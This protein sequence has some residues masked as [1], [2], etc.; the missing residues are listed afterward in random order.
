M[1]E[2]LYLVWPPSRLDDPPRPAAGPRS[3][4][5]SPGSL[6]DGYRLRTYREG[7]RG[8]LTRLIRDEG[9]QFDADER[10][11]YLDRVLPRGLFFVEVADPD[12]VAAGDEGGAASGSG[13]PTGRANRDGGGDRRGVPEV[14][15]GDLVATAGALHDPGGDA[16]YFPFGGS[17]GYVVVAPAHRERGLGR[18]VA[19]AAVRRLLDAGYRSVRVGTEPR[20]LP[21][22]AL[23]LSLG[24]VPFRHDERAIERW[25]R[26][27]ARL[28]RPFDPADCPRPADLPEPSYRE[29]NP[30]P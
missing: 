4:F 21:A 5:G 8:G 16:H 29:P 23:Y 14:R 15:E 12:A 10:A 2:P 22:I 7:D 17:V 30:P 1:P 24:F 27:H 3:E 11:D 18:S 9:W 13:R 19:G 6:P 25:E 20:R 26:I 28:D